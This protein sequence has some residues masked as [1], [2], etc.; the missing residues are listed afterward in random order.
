M[1]AYLY[2]VR[3]QERGRLNLIFGDFIKNKRI[4]KGIS[5]REMASKIGISPSYMS[6]IEKG[7]RY[8]PD[9][10]KL[11][12][13]QKVLFSKE[14]EIQLLYDLAGE[15]RNEVSPDL[16]EYIMENRQVRY[17][18]RQV[19]QDNGDDSILEDINYIVKNKKVRDIVREI[20]EGNYQDNE[21]EF[22]LKLL[23]KKG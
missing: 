19:R 23:K 20:R 8:A 2:N 12:E 7:R 14:E 15:S 18:L 16:P 9:K 3:V 11:S 5:L 1:I 17:L 13:I 4:E 21:L 22:L 6:D 10:D